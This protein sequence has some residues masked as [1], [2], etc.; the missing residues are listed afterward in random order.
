MNPLYGSLTDTLVRDRGVYNLWPWEW[1]WVN[2]AR[3]AEWFSL[4]IDARRL[5]PLEVEAPFGMELYL[6]P[7]GPAGE[8]R[9]TPNNWIPA[10]RSRDLS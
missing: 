10:L 1:V 3:L 4:D 5:L 6:A 2:H 7:I 8:V 9:Y